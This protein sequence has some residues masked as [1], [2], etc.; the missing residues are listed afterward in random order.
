MITTDWDLTVRVVA[1]HCCD[2]ALN[3]ER[4]RAARFH[5]LLMAT[6][7]DGR[8]L[9]DDE[10]TVAL[11]S[12]LARVQDPGALGVLAW[13]LNGLSL[14]YRGWCRLAAAASGLALCAAL[15]RARGCGVPACEHALQRHACQNPNNLV[16]APHLPRTHAHTRT[17]ARGVR[18]AD[19]QAGPPGGG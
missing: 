11:L 6:V 5:E 2:Q 17:Q 15:A 1:T 8:S 7:A 13:L 9:W 16:P 14:R 3:E 4:E 12:E 18:G 10:E 19:Q